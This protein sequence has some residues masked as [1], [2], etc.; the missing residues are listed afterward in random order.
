MIYYG[1]VDKINDE[2]KSCFYGR[3]KFTDE[4][5]KTFSLSNKSDLLALALG[6]IINPLALKYFLF[7]KNQ[8]ILF[9]NTK[10]IKKVEN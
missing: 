1:I 4:E 5:I 8:V 7:K 3:S 9:Y 2:H 6:T 10:K